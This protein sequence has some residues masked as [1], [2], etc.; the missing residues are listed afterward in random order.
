MAF[1]NATGT[2]GVILG[3]STTTTTGSLFISLLMLLII[4]IVVAMFFG[5]RMEYI[6]V[7]VLPLLLAY[8]GYYQNFVAPLGVV[9]IYLATI[10]T[11]VWIFK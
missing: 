10:I 4:L 7:I 9:L 5:I 11:K 6:S 2:L 3:S 8:A 1:I